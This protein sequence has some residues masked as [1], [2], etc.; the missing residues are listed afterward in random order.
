MRK[1]LTQKIEDDD[2]KGVPKDAYKNKIIYIN[3]NNKTNE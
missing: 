2:R 1:N 3:G